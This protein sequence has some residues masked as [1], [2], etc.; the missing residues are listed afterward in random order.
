[1]DL[2]YFAHGIYMKFLIFNLFVISFGLVWAPGI[3]SASCAGADF[4]DLPATQA[5]AQNEPHRYTP[6]DT[7]MKIREQLVIARLI[8]E[9]PNALNKIPWDE[10]KNLGLPGTEPFAR[11]T[12]TMA[13]DL[14]LTMSGG[15]PVWHDCMGIADAPDV[16]DF[17]INCV[18]MYV[19]RSAEQNPEHYDRLTSIEAAYPASCNQLMDRMREIFSGFV[20][21]DIILKR[22]DEVDGISIDEIDCEQAAPFLELAMTA[23]QEQWAE[24][25]RRIAERRAARAAAI[26]NGTY[27]SVQDQLETAFRQDMDRMLQ[28]TAKQAA[29]V[30]QSAGTPTAA[31]VRRAMIAYL[32]Y[33]YPEE[34]ASFGSISSRIIHTI[35]GIRTSTSQGKSLIV[36][37]GP[38]T[39][40]EVTCDPIDDGTATCSMQLTMRATTSFEGLGDRGALFA[41]IAN[42]T[43]VGSKAAK[44]DIELKHNGLQWR[45]ENAPAALDDAL[46]FEQ[47]VSATASTRFTP[48]ECAMLSAMG[49]GGLCG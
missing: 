36:D 21:L 7:C 49:S 10:R 31:H 3:A 12:C 1:M 42:S 22:I 44:I 20:G 41:A 35:G 5:C 16:T 39:L 29:R 37:F 38:A 27:V 45:V 24:T 19:H 11:P 15:R 18:S 4:T 13:S 9:D 14:V 2:Y 33:R 6:T 43:G 26:E 40:D 28:E 25:Q 32:H 47:M 17:A 30:P 23:N 34:D 8:A 46:S 48:E